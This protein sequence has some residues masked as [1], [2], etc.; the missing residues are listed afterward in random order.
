MLP[1]ADPTPA[2]AAPGDIAVAAT[3]TEP[4]FANSALRAGW[5]LLTPGQFLLAAI[6]AILIAGTYSAY[7]INAATPD[8]MEI[9]SQPIDAREHIGPTVRG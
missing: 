7:R 2:W 3:V 1:V 5:R 4:L 8:V 9:A 6:A